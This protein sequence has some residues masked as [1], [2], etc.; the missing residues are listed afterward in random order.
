ME[1]NPGG[2]DG[3]FFGGGWSLFG[4]PRLDLT[5]HSETAYSCSE[6]GE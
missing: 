4:E 2:A 5:P 3:V 1:L 6:R